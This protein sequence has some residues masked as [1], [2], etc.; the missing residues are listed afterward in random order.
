LY[1]LGW[2]ADYVDLSAYSNQRRM[3]DYGLGRNCNLFDYLRNWAYKAIRQ[4][5]PN[6]EQWYE[7]CLTR[8]E[9]YNVKNFKTPLPSGETKATAKSV[10]NFTHKEF[11]SAGFSAWQARQGG[12]VGGKISK[13]GGRP[14]GEHS[15]EKQCL[16]LNRASGTLD[17]FNSK[18]QERMTRERNQELEQQ[19]QRTQSRELSF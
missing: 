18:L 6:Y 16:E 3:P 19:R 1:D 8:A 15:I 13:G 9:G 4:G 11:S 5:W 2:L 10:A 17:G 7:A 12:K 14:K